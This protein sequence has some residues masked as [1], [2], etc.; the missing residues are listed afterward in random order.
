V[1]FGPLTKKLKALRMTH[2][3]WLFQEIQ[4]RPLGC[5]L[6]KFLHAL[7]IDQG[8]LVHTPNRDGGPPKNFKSKHFKFGLKFSTLYNF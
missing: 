2:P 6:L 8:S 3:S 5:W 7:E 1:N 4:F